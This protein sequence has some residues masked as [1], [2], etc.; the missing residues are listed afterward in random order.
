MLANTCEESWPTD[1]QNFATNRRTFT[2]MGMLGPTL[3]DIPPD[4]LWTVPYPPPG[5]VLVDAAFVAKV[6]ELVDYIGTLP[7]RNGGNLRVLREELA[8][9]LPTETP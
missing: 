2:E 8:N 5:K 9:L 1:G 7:L 4:P 6:R 3:S